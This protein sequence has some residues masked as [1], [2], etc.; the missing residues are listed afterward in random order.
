M[1]I[2][3]ITGS[4]GLI[5]SESVK[6]FSKKFSKV[7]GIDNDKRSYFFG[8]SASVKKN[9][10]NI[11]KVYN[12]YFH[13]NFDVRNFV[14]LKKIFKKYN[15]KISFIIHCAAQPS[16]DWAARN[17]FLDYSINSTGTLNIL[18]N[19]RLYSPNAKLAHLSTNKVYG[20]RPNTLPIH[21]K[22]MRYEIKKGNNF[23]NLGIDENMSVDNCKHS[24]FGASKLAADIYCQEYIKYFNLKIGIFRAGC[25]TGPLHQGAELH[26]FLN[27]LI[28][29][30]KEKKTYNI[31][32]YKGKQ[33]RDNIHS[34]DVVSALW[35]FYKTKS[36]SGVYNMGGGRTNSCSILEVIDYLRKNYNIKMKF[37]ILKSNR[38]GDHIWYISNMSKFKKK[39]KKW[40]IKK[41]LNQII[42][43]M[44]RN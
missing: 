38:I 37:K 42:D 29:A 41:K 2:L 11:K 6:F 19:I 25:L 27:Y 15:K 31:F 16:H 30:A 32:G 14:K 5:G 35:E 20:D 13:H 10:L 28:K 18:E 7:I 22:K 33:V 21:E 39:H 23:Y 40:K 26:G 1:S 24:L 36:N 44:V 4:G 43:E 3:L 34:S 12:N 17:P 9:I 8:K